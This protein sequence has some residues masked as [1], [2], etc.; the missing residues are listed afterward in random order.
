MAQI[1]VLDDDEI[2]GRLLSQMLRKSGHQVETALKPEDAWRVMSEV[3]VDLL[4]L[5]TELGEE[6][7]WDVLAKI[8]KDVIFRDLPVIVHSTNSRRDVVERYIDLG[9]Q[10]ILIKPCR[11][12][13]LTSDVEKVMQHPWSDH[14]FEPEDVV[15]SRTGLTANGVRDLYRDALE[16]LSVAR[17]SIEVLKENL[18]DASAQARLAAIRSCAVNV[19]FELMVRFVDAVRAAVKSGNKEAVAEM[20]DRMAVLLRLLEERVGQEEEPEEGEGE[21][22]SEGESGEGEGGEAAA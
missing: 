6:Y 10:G 15:R 22:G 9:V 19:G 16:Q 21:E 4:I 2:S 12:D 8:R 1:L 3:P 14:L 17:E 7:G 20:I 11:A 13:R 18:E 5:D